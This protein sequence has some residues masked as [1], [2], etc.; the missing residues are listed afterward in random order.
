MNASLPFPNPEPV[1]GQY[2]WPATPTAASRLPVLVAASFYVLVFGSLFTGLP[3]T[4]PLGELRGEG[5]LPG[6]MLLLLL[7]GASGA[8]V[9]V[10]GLRA[11]L[12]FAPLLLAVMISY[13]VNAGE[14]GQAHF[15]GRAGGE[16]FLNALMVLAFYAAAFYAVF[17]LVSVYGVEPTLRLAGR[18]AMLATALLVAAMLVEIASWF[19]PPLRS[20]WLSARALWCSIPSAPLFRLTG[21]APEP[22]FGSISAL[23]LIGLLASAV[24]MSGW[25]RRGAAP[26]WRTPLALAL[27]LVGLE[28]I[29][30]SR[31]FLAGVGG[32]AMAALLL[33]PLKRLPPLLR[34]LVIVLAPLVA[35][36]GIILSMMASTPG[37]QSVSNITRS[38]GMLTA[39]ELWTRHPLLGVGLGQYA[40]HFRSVVPSWG[41]QSW[42]VSRYFRYDQIDLAAGVMPPSFSLF[43]RLGA[44]LGIVG[45]LAWSLPAIY[46]IRRALIFSPGRIT[47]VMIC[48]L[49]A[50]IWTGLSLD[51][52][53]NTYYW[54]WLACLLAWPDQYRATGGASNAGD[55]SRAANSSRSMGGRE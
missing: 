15:L 1:S 11:V 40:F 35:Q 17:T 42:E 9:D 37:T 10:R 29:A 30:N 7:A 34:S 4:F 50:Q 22:S 21:F 2:A 44:E 46:A 36:A 12:V 24:T 31:T 3:M 39:T 51:S 14:I 6:F 33:G 38:V 53:R 47:T 55:A 25:P 32:V 16:K 27:A 5:A 19:S 8:I 43:T 48:A 28:M 54:I 13:A 49:A 52:F 45:F 20:A 23:G 26:G 41:L 18:A